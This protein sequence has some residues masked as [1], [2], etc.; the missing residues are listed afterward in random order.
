MTRVLV[1]AASK[2]GAT[3]VSVDVP[4]GDSWIVCAGHTR[5]VID[6]L[7]SCP[8]LGSV[9]LS[10]CLGCHLLVTVAQERDVR[11]ACSMRE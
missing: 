7:I 3:R 9:A 10:D 4:A 8:L 1:T 6:G 2:Q 11:R 5:D